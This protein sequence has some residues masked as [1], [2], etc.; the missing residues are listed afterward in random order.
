MANTKITSHVLDSTLISGHSTV[1]AATND[2]V[3]IQDVSD[4]N[5]LKKAL[6]S[7]LAQN[8]ESPTF[9]GNVTVDGTLTVDTTTLAVDATNNRVGIGTTSPDQLLQVGSESYGANAIIK[10]QVDGSDVGDFDSGLHMRSHN[11]DFGGSIVLESRSGTNDI[12]NFKYHNNSSSGASAMVIDATNGNVA[13]GRTAN[14]AHPLDIQRADNAYIRISSSTTQENAGIIFANQNTTK[15]TLEKVGS[16]HS[17][18]LKDA[19]STAVTFEQGGN[20]GIGIDNP[21]TTLHLDASGGAVLRMQ[22]T[23]TNA[24]NKL[25]LSHDGTNAQITSTNNLGISATQATFDGTV[26]VDGLSNYTGLTVKG[27]GGSRPMIQWSN[28]NNGALCAIYGTEGNEMVLTSGSS[29][30]ERMRIDSTGDIRFGHTGAYIAADEVYTFYNQQ[31]G[32]TISI[33]TAGNASHYG[34][35]MWNQVGGSCNQMLFRGGGS[36]AATGS[37]TSTG[38]NATQFNTSS[39]YRLKENVDYTWDALTR[40]NQLKPC[41]FNWIDDDTNTLEDGFLAHEVSSVVPNAV[42]GEKDAVYTEEEAASEM[43][44]NAGDIKR[45]Q[46]DNSKLV[47]LLVKAIQEQQ[48]QIEEL[49]REIEALKS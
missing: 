3:L 19:S 11:D 8:E 48:E 23:S 4:S 35:D 9:T 36:G 37:I 32:R 41:R 1:T 5:A 24:S 2:F 22:R 20:V 47:P 17:L 49:K 16:A 38:N 34:I 43:Y 12:I 15:W 26:L 45:Q 21:A 39:D 46:L 7:D 25:E 31:K 29:N 44:I 33:A 27:S 42:T 10:T 30:T 14:I 18:F 40:L 6:V 28:A 13:I